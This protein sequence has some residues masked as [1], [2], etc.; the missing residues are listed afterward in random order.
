MA[1]WRKCRGLSLIICFSIVVSSCAQYTDEA[2]KSENADTKDFQLFGEEK[3]AFGNIMAPSDFDWRSCE[4]ITLDF[5]VENNIN[6][7][8]L[9][10]ESEK[11]TAVTGINV[12]IR[13][14]DFATMK[15]KI[16]IEFISQIGQYELIYLDPYQT[17]PIFKDYL[18]DLS[19]YEEDERLPHIVGG[20]ESFLPEQVEVCSFYKDKEKLY[21][22]PFDSTTMVLYYRKDIFEKYGEQMERELGYLPTPGSLEFTWERYLEVSDWIGKNVDETQIR[23]PSITMSADHNSIYTEFSNYVSAYGGDYFKP[24]DLGLLGGEQGY[25]LMSDT[26]EF[27]QALT[28]Y[29]KAVHAAKMEEGLTWA[30]TANLFQNG[31]VAMMLNWDE[32]AAK[33]ENEKHSKVAGKTGYSILPYGSKRSANIYGGSGIGINKHVSEEKKL[34]AWMFIVWCTSP[35]VQIHTFLEED[36][37]NMPTRRNLQ[38][39]IF[40]S[41]M[42]KLPQAQAVIT[43]QKP[44]HVYYRPKIEQGYEFEMLIQ[45]NLRE[46]ISEDIS[47]EEIGEKMK[48]EWNTIVESRELVE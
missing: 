16:S 48:A 39:L 35:Q 42:V 28:M 2:R 45:R 47:A 4:G 10:K 14:M 9:S 18:E 31:E 15:E 22:I 43:A 23:Y 13:N 34:A 37:G 12:R 27:V 5:I 17:L 40:A 1:V 41:Y 44:A 19:Y 3:N 33:M 25:E 36:G 46:Y 6:A 38:Q 24:V 20:L 21:A 8:I 30:E 11:F 29:K 26:E 32:N 7:N